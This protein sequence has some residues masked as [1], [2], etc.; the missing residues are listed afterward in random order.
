MTPRPYRVVLVDDVADIRR[1]VGFILE[2]SQRFEVVGEAA[3]GKEAVEV[4]A[5]TLPDAVL[6]DLSMPVMDGLECLPLV[7]AASP[8]TRVVVFSGFEEGRMAS[9]AMRQGAS[10]YL[11]KG[12]APDSIVATLLRVA[13]QGRREETRTGRPPGR[14]A[15][16]PWSGPAG[17][18]PGG[19][20]R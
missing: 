3:D 9:T 7:L 14:S 20:P 5:R 19:G 6:L 4:V 1:L 16:P 12:A 2:D 13:A 18:H 15:V 11:E 8:G 10:A 17:A